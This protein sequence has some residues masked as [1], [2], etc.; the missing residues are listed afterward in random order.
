M[1]QK[2]KQLS[3]VILRDPAVASLSSFIGA[4]GTNSTLNSGRIQINL[5]S[6]ADRH[7]TA[8][9]VVTRLQKTVDQVPG[10]HLY[11]QPVQDLTVDDRV[12]RTQ[13]QY[14]LEDPD[15][16]ELNIWTAKMVSELR[17]LPQLSDVATDQQN[18]SV[19]LH[20]D[21]DR[22]TASRLNITPDQIDST[23]YDA[24]G[25]R[26]VSTLYTQSNQYHVI[27]EALPEFQT[28]ADKLTS[29]YIQGSSN[30]SGSA[31]S[32]S[33]RT[34]AGTSGAASTLNASSSNGFSSS[35][36]GAIASTAVGNST[37]VSNTSNSLGSSTNS[38]STLGSATPRS[39]LACLQGASCGVVTPG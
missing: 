6:A 18:D 21:I 35:T 7:L 1:S 3:D 15:I 28:S 5:K 9:E 25:H 27:L 34:S 37:S 16:S 26:Q 20:L 24:F 39:M 10:I 19:S 14:T 29:L 32:T 38:G 36:T 31:Q 17:K 12:S 22:T 2:Q 4:D 30:G 8:A 33:G 11:L 13:Y 23:L